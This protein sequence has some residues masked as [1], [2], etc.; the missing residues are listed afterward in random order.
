MILNGLYHPPHITVDPDRGANNSLYLVHHFEDKPLVKDYIAN[1]MMG[2]EYLW[3][4]PIKLETS[5]VVSTNGQGTRS[6]FP[7][8]P[9]T[10]E[11]PTKETEV[12]WQRILYT[13]EN[14][15]LSKQSI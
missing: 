13:M 14:R 8:Y 11:E 2:I 12:K 1:T 15:T 10:T 4:G 5:E 6:L 9:Q 7:R 3:G